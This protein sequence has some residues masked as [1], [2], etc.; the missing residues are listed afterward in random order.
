MKLLMFKQI[1]EYIEPI[2]NFESKFQ[3]GS[4][5]ELSAQY[6]LLSVLQKWKKV[7][8]N[9]KIFDARLTDLSKPFDCLSHDLLL[10]KLNAYGFSLPALRFMQ[11]HL[12]N[13][14]LRTKV[15]SKFSS[16]EEILF[17]VRQE[18]ILGPLLFSIVLR[19][20][21]FIMNNV[22]FT[23]YA[24]DKAPSF[25]VGKDL[26]EVIFK[27]ISTSKTLFQWFADNKNES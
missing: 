16:W 24:D 27:F 6:C 23:S 5:K 8:D 9:K 15:S 26:D 10:A 20:L 13:R 14:K 12:P 19:D 25:F 17:G 18:S 11:S 3:C 7:V 4:R 2:L 1:S 21:F 22:D